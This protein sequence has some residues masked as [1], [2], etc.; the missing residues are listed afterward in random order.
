MPLRVTGQH[1]TVSREEH[2]YIERKIDRLRRYFDKINKMDVIC[3]QE[4]NRKTVEILITAT[5]MNLQAHEESSD[6]TAAFDKCIDKIERQIKKQKAKLVGNKKHPSKNSRGGAP[7]EAAVEEDDESEIMRAEAVTPSVLSLDE[8]LAELNGN[9]PGV[10][11][12]RKPK[13]LELRILVRQSDE[14]VRLLEVAE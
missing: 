9:N 5:H 2:D 7:V 6:M 13:T 12:F 1:Y 14:N 3:K 8:A 4:K 10:I 11:V